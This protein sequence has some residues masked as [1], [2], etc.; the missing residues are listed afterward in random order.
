MKKER[1]FC[2]AIMPDYV[3]NTSTSVLHE[4]KGFC[5]NLLGKTILAHCF[6]VLQYYFTR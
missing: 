3:Y 6:T 5:R 1:D 4:L 2:A